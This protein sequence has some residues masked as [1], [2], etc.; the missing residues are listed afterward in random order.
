[1][2]LGRD[3]FVRSIINKIKFFIFLLSH[4]LNKRHK[5]AA[6]IRY[7]RWQ[8]GSRLV[9]GIVVFN[10]I[11]DT[12]LLAKPGMDAATLNIYT[13]LYEFED[14]SFVLHCLRKDDMFIDIGA[15][16]GCY[17]VLAGSAVGANCISIEPIP[18]TYNYWW[19]M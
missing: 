18:S 5:F 8:L 15:N 16:I 19:I 6:L 2:V 14:M 1:M 3:G 17:T 4:P 7:V 10:Y 11:N 13:G 12:R 9:P